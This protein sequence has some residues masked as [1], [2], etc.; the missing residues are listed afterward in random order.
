MTFEDVIHP[1]LIYFAFS[2]PNGREYY[3]WG[4]DEAEAR[5]ALSERFK[6]WPKVPNYKPE[7]LTL[8]WQRKR[9]P[10]HRWRRH[11]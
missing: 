7:E 1:N 10:A 11:R 2:A 4:M 3:A 5:L 6:L 8:R 9:V